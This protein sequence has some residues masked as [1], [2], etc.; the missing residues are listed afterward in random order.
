MFL[1]IALTSSVPADAAFP[2]SNGKILFFSGGNRSEPGSM[3][4]M[5]L[6][7]SQ[8]TRLTDPA[9][10]ESDAQWSAD[11][12]HI[13]FERRHGLSTDTFQRAVWMIRADGSA[14]TRIGPK[15]RGQPS[16]SPDGTRIV[17]VRGLFTSANL[18]I[19]DLQG[20]IVRR[21]T[22]TFGEEAEP[23]WSPDGSAIAF[24]MDDPSSGVM[25][26]WT[27][28]ATGGVPS[29]VTSSG[30]GKSTIDW[31]PDG[32][33]LAYTTVESPN[34]I[35]VVDA[36]GSNDHIILGDASDN[37]SPAWSPDGTVI[38]FARST[39]SVGNADIWTM[40]PDGSDL[41]QLTSRPRQETEPDWQPIP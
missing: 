25:E 3:F 18:F 20:E 38:A 29:R 32:A 31:S 10:Y 30:I 13:V 16:I 19:M 41:M 27:M 40:S 37:S 23:E 28:P 22:S 33:R 6:D 14:S 39:P 5:N 1:G 35:G 4:S 12:T 21:L 24:L 2:G 15:K 34:R 9:I 36:D 8:R 11:G 7:G 26:I 17:F